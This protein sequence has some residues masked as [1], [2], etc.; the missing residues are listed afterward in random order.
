MEV[1]QYMVELTHQKNN[2]LAYGYWSSFTMLKSF[3]A[4]FLYAAEVVTA[5]VYSYII[6]QLTQ[7]ILTNVYII[8]S[9]SPDSRAYWAIHPMFQH[10]SHFPL[11]WSVLGRLL[12]SLP[13]RILAAFQGMYLGNS[14]YRTRLDFFF[15][16]HHFHF[17]FFWF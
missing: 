16:F 11:W 8:A 3:V 17:N 14:C 9:L 10:I 12:S 1:V 5:C 13:L 6:F 7:V 4:L 2:I 15:C